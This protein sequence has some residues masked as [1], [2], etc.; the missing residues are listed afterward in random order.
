MSKAHIANHYIQAYIS[1]A[2][3]QGHSAEALLKPAGIPL[4][5]LNR[6]DKPI[7]E[8][9]LTQLIQTI[10]QATQ[11]EFFGLAPQVCKIDVFDLMA[12]FAYQ[13]K[14]FGGFLRQ[15]ARFYSTVCDCIEIGLAALPTES[16]PIFFRLNLCDNRKD[17]D[18][19]LQE[20]LLLMWQ[21]FGSWLVGQKIPFTSTQFSYRAPAH[22]KEYQ[23]M[24]SG[25]LLY[26]QDCCGFSLHPRFLQLP[27]IKSD[28]EL[29]EFLRESPAYILHRPDQDDSLQTRIRLILQE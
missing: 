29:Q 28:V 6:P 2:I 20:F 1:G 3:K 5:W 13:A 11:D 17:K 27:I 22:A 26:E 25:E 18:H 8:Q 14:T 15:S 24:F 23:A 16:R 10:M 21:R 9:Q 12:E 4:Q 19:F 7:T